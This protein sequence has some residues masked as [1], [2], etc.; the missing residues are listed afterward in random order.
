MKKKGCLFIISAP[1]G[2]GKSTVVGELLKRKAD[3]HYS[4]SY[5]TRKPRK[6]EKDGVDYRFVDEKT[7]KKLIDEDFFAEWANVYGS[8]YGTPKKE[9]KDAL[10][11]GR[12]VI[13]DIDV[14]GGMNLKKKFPDAVTIFLTPPS[15][16]VLKKRLSGRKTDS[17][18]EIAKRLDVS[19]MEMGCKDKYD[20]CVV[21][22]SVSG[23][24]DEISAIMANHEKA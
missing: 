19:R 6:G 3:L 12:S 5:T 23:A 21:N 14:Q 10:A 18:E 9:I 1:S 7:F 17:P 2:T 24:C 22:D 11:A 16:E 13:F 20:Y 4:I 8:F 15:F